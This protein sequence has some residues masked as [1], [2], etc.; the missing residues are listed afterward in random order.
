[1]FKGLTTIL[2]AIATNG[3]ANTDATCLKSLYVGDVTI[4]YDFRHRHCM[5][6]CQ[7]RY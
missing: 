5:T 3:M 6:R 7:D 2:S 4:Y 1:V